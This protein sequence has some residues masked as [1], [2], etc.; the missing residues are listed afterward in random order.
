MALAGFCIGIGNMW[1]FPYIVGANGGGTFLIVY[2]ISV[3]AVGLPLFILEQQLG[4]SSQLSG[5]AGMEKL[6]PKHKKFW[7]I[8]GGWFG[9]ITIMLIACYFWSILGWNIGYIIKVAD[10]SLYGLSNEAVTQTFVDFSGSWACVGCAAIAAVMCWLMMSTDFK[11]GVEKVCKF[12]L[13]TLIVL[14]I[15][16]A[17]YSAS[18]PGAGAGLE[19]YLKPEFSNTD[20]FATVQAAVVQVFYSVG[21]GMSCAFVYGSYVKKNDNLCGNSLTAVIMDTLVAVLSGLV[22]TPALFAFGIEPAAG[23]GLIFI[24]LPQMF[25][26]MGNVPGRIFGLIF[27]FAVFLACITSMAAILESIVANMGDKFGWSRKKG[28]NF[29]ILV[30][31]AVSIIVTLNQGSGSLTGLSFFGM[32]LFSLLDMLGSAFGLTLTAIFMVLFV[33]FVK[34][35]SWFQKEANMGAGR[36]RIGSWMKWYYYVIIPVIL[37]FVFYC[38]LRMYFG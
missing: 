9:L 20:M 37:A 19:W 8:T 4:R 26:A 11:K 30:P 5:I 3:V 32:D 17:I 1:K 24:S 2:I 36:F 15:G 18:L 12:A 38:I 28:R 25:T 29:A 31:F 35:F 23:P 7:S 33:I 16:L 27:L 22:I 21:I 34:K 6:A 10:G 13:P 14:M